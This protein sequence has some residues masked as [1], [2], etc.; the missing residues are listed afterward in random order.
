MPFVSSGS[1]VLVL[2]SG[3]FIVSGAG[4]EAA[5]QDAD[6]PVRELAQRSV[7]TDLPGP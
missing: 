7:M 4:L 2:P 6:E 1:D 5:V 3:V